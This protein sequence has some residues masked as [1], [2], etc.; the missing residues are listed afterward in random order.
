VAVAGGRAWN[1]GSLTHARVP[2]GLILRACAPN[3][4][5]WRRAGTLECDAATM[6]EIDTVTSPRGCPQ[7]APFTLLECLQPLQK[8]A[9]VVHLHWRPAQEAMHFGH[10][11]LSLACAVPLPDVAAV[12]CN[13]SRDDFMVDVPQ[14]A[15]PELAQTSLVWYD[16]AAGYGCHATPADD[17][18]FL[19][20]VAGPNRVL[21]C[22][23]VA[24]GVVARSAADA[25]KCDFECIAPLVRQR[26]ACVSPCAGLSATC[27]HAALSAC[28]DASG[29][30]FFNCSVCPPRP[31]FETKAFDAQAPA[32]ECAYE[33]CLPGTA[34]SADEH[35]CS[36]CRA[37]AIAADARAAGCVSC[38]TS[39]TGLFS[40]APGGTECSACLEAQGSA[41]ALCGEAVFDFSTVEIGP[42]WKDYAAASGFPSTSMF[43]W[44]DGLGM[45]QWNHAAKI[46]GPL[47]VGYDTLEVAFYATYDG[48]V[49]LQIDGITKAKAIMSC[50]QCEG[51]RSE[52]VIYTQQYLPGQ[53]LRIVEMGYGGIG[54]DLK[55]TL[56][57]AKEA[58][59]GEGRGLY[60]EFAEV[61]ALFALYTADRP[62]ILLKDYIEGFCVQ[63]YACLPC[64]PGTIEQ[65]GLCEECGHGAYMPN[66]GATECFP[67]AAGQN[68][69]APGQHASAACVC[70]PGFE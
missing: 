26:L 55:I 36:P 38:N 18:S 34:S 25:T 46:E 2:E 60:T 7:T 52:T 6:V 69:T 58:L 33:E 64:A 45:G 51:E 53:V 13:R 17:S 56:R 10:L 29:G 35:T 12:L 31:G 16:F 28:V 65:N 22:P 43:W 63:G 41:E 4:D 19:S 8:A 50:S 9:S 57:C 21:A 14:A 24:G 70:T 27:P 68:T 30:R 23:G 37:N 39:T 44:G 5:L 54:K 20:Q 67:C 1:F 40:R 59:C 42:P 61:E 15:A 11:P 66:F 49:W 62:A 32:S 3:F 47:P 48:E